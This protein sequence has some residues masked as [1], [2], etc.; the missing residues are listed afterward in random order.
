VELQLYRRATR[1]EHE[2]R[3][4][5]GK[6]ER[7]LSRGKRVRVITDYNP[8]DNDHFVAIFEIFE[9]LFVDFKQRITRN[10]RFTGRSISSTS[11]RLKMPA[12]ARPVPTLRTCTSNYSNCSSVHSSLLNVFLLDLDKFFLSSD[13]ST[14]LKRL[15]PTEKSKPKISTFQ[16]NQ[17][18]RSTTCRSRYATALR[19]CK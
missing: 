13:Y 15:N 14:A 2:V 17:N 4:A 18:D 9:N 1:R 7:V 16:R 3:A 12:M 5:T 19:W 8:T 11:P 6:P 10:F